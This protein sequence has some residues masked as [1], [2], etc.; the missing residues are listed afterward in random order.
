[1]LIGCQGVGGETYVGM[2]TSPAWFATAGPKTVAAYFRKS[3]E[4]YGFKADTPQMAQCIQNEAVSRRG[5]A[6]GF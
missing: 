3:C 2:P 4:A 5:L 1:M 6:A